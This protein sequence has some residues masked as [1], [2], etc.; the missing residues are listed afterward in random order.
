M[1]NLKAAIQVNHPGHKSTAYLDSVATKSKWDVLVAQDAKL[2]KFVANAMLCGCAKTLALEITNI[3]ENGDTDFHYDYCENIKDGRGYTSGIAGFCTGTG[4]AWQVVQA[5]HTLTGGK[6]DMSQ[7]DTVMEKLA[8]CNSNCGSITGLGGYCDVWKKLGQT[9]TK[10]KQAQDTIRDNL[11]FSPAMVYATQLGLK[12]S[13]A[14][15]QLYDAG[16]QHGT[17]GG[18]DSLGGM[19]KSTNAQIT[20][21]ITGDSNSILTINGHSVD[22]IAWLNK[23][24]A[25][26]TGILKNPKES[27]DQGGAWAQTLYRINSYTYAVGLKEYMWGSSVKVLDNDGKPTTVT[28]STTTTTTT[29]KR[30]R[31]VAANPCPEGFKPVTAMPSHTPK[32]MNKGKNTS[33]SMSKVKNTSTSTSMST[34]KPKPT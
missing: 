32:S 8:N 3:Y 29:T 26:R 28:C 34:K 10:F 4:D 17:D 21:D 22:E 30:K 20:A 1:G 14:Q 16:I 27:G 11:Y 23:F 19:V 18:A 13:I 33:T 15:A 9:D 25:V 31:K 12:T 24:L 6:D 2:F 7:Y 5:Y